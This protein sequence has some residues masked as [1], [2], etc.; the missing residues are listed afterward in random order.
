MGR[1]T[2]G[3]RRFMTGRYGNDKLNI[4]ILIT[5]LVACLAGLFVPHALTGLL[6][7][8]LSYVLMFWAI[9]RMYSR[10]TWKRYRENQRYLQFW[11]RIRDRKHKYY[12]CPRCRQRV[13]VPRGEGK[14]AITC[15]KCKEKFIRKT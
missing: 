8:F 4:A 3:M 14:I 10:N 13:R 12:A 9:F 11:E 15:P 6:L 7:T 2:N 5:G 1:F